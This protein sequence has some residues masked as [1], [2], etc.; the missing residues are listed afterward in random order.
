[1]KI[2]GIIPARYESTRFPGKPL[3]DIHGK[4]MIQHVFEKVSGEVKDVIIATDDYRIE[5]C[6]KDFGGQV[7]MTSNKHNSGTNRCIEAFEVYN[8]LNPDKVFDIVINIQGDEPT[9]KPTQ[10]IEL[11][12][13]FEDPNT[14]IATLVKKINREEDIFNSN[15]VKAIF[16]NNNY[17]LYFSR[18]P[19]PY[20]RDKQKD[21]WLQACDFFKHI[22][23]YAFRSEIL[24]KIKHLP[25]SMLERSEA[26]EQ[27]NW[28]YHGF[29]IRV[30]ETSYENIGIDTPE[31]LD[32]LLSNWV[33]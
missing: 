3:V 26:L 22:G 12:N 30:E 23:I 17:A 1:M 20:V 28:L 25:S 24:S 27:L 10:L 18:S 19:I 2:L 7:V 32:K 11:I 16:S 21:E 15:V 13:C 33:V 29:T 14:D 6:V 4:P 5:K 8:K 31:D 9:L